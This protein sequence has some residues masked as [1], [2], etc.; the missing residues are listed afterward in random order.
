[1]KKVIHNIGLTD[2]LDEVL[3]KATMFGSFESMKK[4]E[5]SNLGLRAL[6]TP[7]DKNNPNAYK[8]RKGIIGDHKNYFSLEVI[9]ELN[10]KIQAELPEEFGYKEL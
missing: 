4:L 5:E 2:L 7:I 10:K 3:F 6:K 9:R 1:M 8:V